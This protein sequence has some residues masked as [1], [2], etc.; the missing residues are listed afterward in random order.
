LDQVAAQV[1]ALVDGMAA[2]PFKFNVRCFSG[3]AIR[4]N[5]Q[6][7]IRLDRIADIV[8]GRFQR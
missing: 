8:N 7:S 2:G 6:L 3:A 1:R 5:K 4:G